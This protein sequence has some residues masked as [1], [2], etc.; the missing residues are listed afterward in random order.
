MIYMQLK[1][2]KKSFSGIN[3]FHQI[4]LDI[5]SNDR[6]AIVGRNGTGK[7]TLLK[8]MTGAISYDEGEIFQA[9][10]IS[11]GYLAQLKAVSSQYT[12]WEELMTV[13]TELIQEEKELRK[14]AEKIES[15]SANG[16]DNEQ[17]IIDRKSTRL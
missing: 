15:L 3:L 14:L 5:K 17:L 1:N 9:K 10:N 16:G 2:I 8:I 13:F 12:I 7:S 4:S 6:I 11:I